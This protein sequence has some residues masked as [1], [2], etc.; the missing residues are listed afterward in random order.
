MPQKKNPDAL[1]LLRGK[2]GRMIGNLTGMLATLKGVP[3]CAQRSA[4]LRVC[5]L[6]MR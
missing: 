5:P 3:R 4:L 1:E 2:A 6:V